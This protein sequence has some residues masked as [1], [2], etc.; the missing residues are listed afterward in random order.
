MKIR[1]RGLRG[2]P[3]R[4]I[5][6]HSCQCFSV[7]CLVGRPICWAREKGTD[8]PFQGWKDAGM[9]DRTV[10]CAEHGN[11]QSMCRAKYAAE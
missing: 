9:C 7:G 6:R 3:E 5:L 4:R 8:G 2:V 10:G 1:I 11:G